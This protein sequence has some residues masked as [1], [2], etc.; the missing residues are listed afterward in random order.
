LATPEFIF[1]ISSEQEFFDACLSTF[2]YQ[3]ENNELYKKYVNLIGGTTH[4]KSPDEITFLPIEFFKTQEIKTG[5]WIAEAEFLSSS[6]TG[7]GQSVHRVRYLKDYESSFAKSFQEVYGNPQD[8][9]WLCLLP[10]YLER[11][12]SSLIYMANFFIENSTFKQSGF[13]LNEYKKLLDLLVDV[14][15]SKTPTILLGVTFGLLGFVEK[16]SLDIPDLIVMETGGM[17]GR[18]EEMTREEV[19]S[20]LKKGFGV[21]QIHSEYGMT[22]LLSQAYSQGEGL[23]N[24]PP[25]MRVLTRDTTD[26]KKILNTDKTGG[27]NIID[28]ANYHTCS[29]IATQDLGKVYP[30]GSFEI[31]GRFDHSDVRGCNL[32]AV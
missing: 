8:F 30:D 18:R 14:Q 9:L 1:N 3:L 15:N 17:K 10:S 13:F 12:G 31:L 19:H 11:E 29:F 22:E 25:W 5:D 23:F 20:V 2:H 26:P 6:T 28:L 24:C 27:I 7:R 21:K 4:P 16:C 32:L